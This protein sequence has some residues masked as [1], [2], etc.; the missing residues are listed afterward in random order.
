MKYLLAILFSL[1]LS[2]A[3]AQE[4]TSFLKKCFKKQYQ[5]GKTVKAVT[6]ALYEDLTGD[7]FG[8]LEIQLAN[9]IGPTAG[10]LTSNCQGENGKYTCTNDKGGKI[11]FVDEGATG[12]LKIDEALQV[13]TENEVFP[14]KSTVTRLPANNGL[15]LLSA[16]PH[17]CD[18]LV[19]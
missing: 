10:H 16:V 13:K 17:A 14:G 7:T 12:V 2:S 1:S 6:L 9:Q 18:K 8:S 15:K 5:N 19:P 3:F 11:T 4:S